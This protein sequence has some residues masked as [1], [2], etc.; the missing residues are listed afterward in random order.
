M[1]V[2]LLLMIVM[3]LIFQYR[4]EIII[5]HGKIFHHSKTAYFVFFYKDYIIIDIS[6][7]L[8]DLDFS[9]IGEPKKLHHR[10]YSTK[11]QMLQKA[12]QISF[13]NFRQ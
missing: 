9:L 2:Y 4:M 1:E 6:F 11:F 13:P 5:M 7:V 8:F 12:Y 10:K 3:H